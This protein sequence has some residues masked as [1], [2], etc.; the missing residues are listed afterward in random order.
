MKKEKEIKFWKGNVRRRQQQLPRSPKRQQQQK[1]FAML[2]VVPVLL[3]LFLRGGVDCFSI[4]TTRRVRITTTCLSA[5]KTAQTIFVAGSAPTGYGRTSPEPNPS[6]STVAQQLARR[7][8]N[9]CNTGADHDDNAAVSAVAIK[10]LELREQPQLLCNSANNAE[11]VDTVVVALG[12]STPEEEQAFASALEKGSNNNNIRAILADPT[13]GIATQQLCRAG[14][15]QISSAGLQ[16][17]V[18]SLAPWSK[19]ASGKRLLEKTRILLERKS[20]EDYIFAVLFCLN[21]LTSVP[22]D[23]VKNG[24]I[25]PSWEKGIVRNV[26]EFATMCDKCGPQIASALTDPQTKSAIDLLNACDLRDQVGSYRVIVSNETPQLE[27]FTLCIL[28]QN[29]CFQCNAPILSQPRVPLFDKWRRQPLT[30]ETSRQILIG[31][32]DHPAACSDASQ[33]KD[34]SWKVVLG[35]NPAYDAFPLQH[36]IF[37][38]SSGG[39]G[40]SLWYDPVFAVDTLQGDRVWCKRHYRCTPRRHWSDDNAAGAWTLST[41]DNGMVSEEHWTIVDAAD[42]LS[43]AVLHYSGAAK[44]AGQS[45][46]GALLCSPDGNFPTT[47]GATYERIR[48]AFQKCDLELWELFGASKE[49]SYM[50]SGEQVTWCEANPPPLE[51]IGDVSITTWRKREREKQQQKQT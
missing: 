8:P 32:L 41:L 9:F 10:A 46:V 49:Q 23:V 34:W 50:W 17:V 20:S 26:Q 31:H 6:W 22:I 19:L 30:Q 12:V 15:Y 18:A 3:L 13:C 28:Q 5:A 16:N 29:D 36:Q 24:D 25:N 4:T 42:D 39:K 45:Y 21:A 14:S 33:K 40:K 7:L 43:W 47:T 51:R 44:R 35:A 37:Y 1:Q 11:D 2:W 48:Q 27:D 38:P